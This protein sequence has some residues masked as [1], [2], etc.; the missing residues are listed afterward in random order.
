MMLCFSFRRKATLI[1]HYCLVAA[2]QCCTEPGPFS[3]EGIRRWKRMEL[4]QLTYIGKG[5]ILH[6]MTSCRRS[7][8]RRET[9]SFSLPML[10]E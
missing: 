8:E 6:H 4:G 10:W 1:T 9:S 3:A 5:D 7:V 2:K